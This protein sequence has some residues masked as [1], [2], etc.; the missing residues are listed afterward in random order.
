MPVLRQSKRILRIYAN[1]GKGCSNHKLHRRCAD[2]PPSSARLTPRRFPYRR[3]FHAN[4]K[5]QMRTWLRS[6]DQAIFDRVAGK[7]SRPDTA[8]CMI[9][10]ADFSLGCESKHLPP[11]REAL[12]HE[13][14]LRKPTEGMLADVAFLEKLTSIIREAQ[15]L[16]AEDKSRLYIP[17]PLIERYVSIASPG[18]NRS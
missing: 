14:Q 1:C 15:E 16:H 2:C 8:T 7:I 12:R 4:G 18:T 10:D 17:L 3:G 13:D 11:S 9:I 6:L 5:K